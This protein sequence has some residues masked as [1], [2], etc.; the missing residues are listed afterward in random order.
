MDLGPGPHRRSI[1][2]RLADRPG[3]L[4]RL[5]GIVAE[6]GVNIVRLEIVSSEQADVWDDVEMAAASPQQLDEVIRELRESGLSVIGLPGSWV[7]R[8]WAIEVLRTLEV[9]AESKDV[10]DALTRFVAATVTLTQTNHAFVLMEPQPPN[11]ELAAA[12]WELLRQ[13]A[14]EFDPGTVEWTGD[15]GMIKVVSAA[16]I[17]ARSDSGDVTEPGAVGAV[18]RIPAPGGRPATLAV[19]GRRPRLLPTEVSRLE[20]FARVAAP[21]IVSNRWEAIA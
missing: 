21:H 6:A 17:A 19:V 14:L 1:R 10:V 5:S 15:P 3:S 18:V 11:P 7:I 12:R 8:D 20:L 4:H 16:M 13:A 2:V 9:M